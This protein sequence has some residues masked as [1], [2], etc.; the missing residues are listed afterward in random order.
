MKFHLGKGKVYQEISKMA[1][2]LKAD[3]LF[4]GTHGI[5]GYE[6]YWIGSNAYRITTS[7]PCPVVTVR[8]GY[9]IPEQLT[10]IL[11]PWTARWK[12]EKSFLLPSHWLNCSMRKSICS[13]FTIH[14]WVSF[15]GASMLL[16][17]KH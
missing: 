17:K 5:S 12:P 2:R 16:E 8:C 10:Q 13:K 1:N 4:T 6:Q 15:A 7:A 3:L 14:R 9:D 11:L